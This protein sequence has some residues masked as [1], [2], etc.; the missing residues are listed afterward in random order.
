MYTL[1]ILADDLT[2]A[3]DTGVQAAKKG[4]PVRVFFSPEAAEES[5]GGEDGAGSRG[6]AQAVLVINTASRHIPPSEAAAITASC[7]RRHGDIPFVYKKT[8][9]ALRGNI[10]AELDALIHERGGPLPFVPAWPAMGRTTAEGRQ[11]L[12]GVPVDKTELARDELNPVRR[13]FIP[14]I[15]A[16]QSAVP[17]ICAGRASR[18]RHAELFRRESPPEPDRRVI[19]FDG[20]SDGD[21]SDAAAL[22]AGENMTGASAGCAGFAGALMEVLPFPPHAGPFDPAGDFPGPRPLLVVCGS[23]HPVSRAQIRA[24]QKDRVPCTAVN[25]GRLVGGSGAEAAASRCAEFLRREKICIL[26]TEASLGTAE[27]SGGTAGE[28]AALLGKLVKHITKKTG[29]LHLA[30]FGGDVL[31]GIMEALEYEYLVPL[32]EIES[33]VA[34]SLAKGPSR[35][36]HVAAKAGAFGGENL[37]Q[38]IRGYFTSRENPRKS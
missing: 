15:I 14:D 4:L 34:V 30:V 5:A 22:L 36:A 13:S 9:S 2:G 6:G 3:L 17:V 8:D 33:G 16:E 31:L 11:F 10:G 1:L 25:T 35:S 32:E 7:L 12:R 18:A 26:G 37:I 19:V 20:E 29:P 24:A 38:K 21:L 23:R 27:T 28:T